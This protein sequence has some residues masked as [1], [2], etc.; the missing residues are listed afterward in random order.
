MMLLWNGFCF[1]Y[2][3]KDV[4]LNLKLVVIDTHHNG[5]SDILICML[6]SEVLTYDT[7]DTSCHITAC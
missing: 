4:I 7:L 1:Y 5:F 6:T 2:V 3:L